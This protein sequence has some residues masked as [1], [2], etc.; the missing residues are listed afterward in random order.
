M[1]D[2]N[3]IT[4]EDL[5][6]LKEK[7]PRAYHKE[8]AERTGLS[9]SSVNQVMNG[10]FYNDKVLRAAIDYAREYQEQLRETRNA[11]NSL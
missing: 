6:K 8:L 5:R 10:H 3:L 4:A 1:Q 11:I 2:S 9:I 7:L